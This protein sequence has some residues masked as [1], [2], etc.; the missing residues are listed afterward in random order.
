MGEGDKDIKCIRSRGKSRYLEDPSSNPGEF[1]LLSFPSPLP[2]PSK[3]SHLE[4]MT[5]IPPLPLVKD[6]VF[7]QGVDSNRQG[8]DKESTT[9]Q[10]RQVLGARTGSTNMQVVLTEATSVGRP[11]VKPI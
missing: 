7:L 8:I 6:C 4:V 2:F 5:K 10:A 1:P 3:S 11:R 9:Y